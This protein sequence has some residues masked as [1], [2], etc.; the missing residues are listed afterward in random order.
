VHDIADPVGRLAGPDRGFRTQ[1]PGERPP[2][3]HQQVLD[4][5]GA[6]RDRAVVHPRVEP[7]P[8]DL[9]RLPAVT[10]RIEQPRLDARRGDPGAGPVR[11]QGRERHA[12]RA[13]QGVE[14]AQGRIADPVL[15]LR[16][17]PLAHSGRVRERAHGQAALPSRRA[18]PL[19]YEVR[20]VV[21]G[22]RV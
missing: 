6:V 10:G 15:D 8:V 16:Q 21:H 19:T 12:E 4:D 17:R 9:D 14:R 5:T 7:Q 22:H 2:G 1:A 18:Q 3:G 13:R 11:D 20:E